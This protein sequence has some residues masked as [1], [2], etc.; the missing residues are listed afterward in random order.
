MSCSDGLRV[1]DMAVLQAAW[2]TDTYYITNQWPIMYKLKKK[3]IK[4][5]KVKPGGVAKKVR[6]QVVSL[7]FTGQTEV[8]W[9]NGTFVRQQAC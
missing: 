2:P 6:K 1:S 9:S 3:P 7:R 5:G 8:H 4:M